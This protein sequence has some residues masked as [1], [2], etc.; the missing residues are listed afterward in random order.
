[1]HVETQHIC[2]IVSYSLGPEEK[3]LGFDRRLSWINTADIIST[4]K[5]D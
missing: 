5:D 1:M 2:L 4:T 3:S